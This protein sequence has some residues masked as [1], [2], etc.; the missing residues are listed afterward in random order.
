MTHIAIREE[1]LLL[2]SEIEGEQEI[3]LIREDTRY[4]IWTK[5]DNEQLGM[6][7]EN[8]WNIFTKLKNMDEILEYP[9]TITG[10]VLTESNGNFMIKGIGHMKFDEY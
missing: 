6:T 9:N 8:L 2:D 4:G 7:S 1:D 3:V 5:L 10:L